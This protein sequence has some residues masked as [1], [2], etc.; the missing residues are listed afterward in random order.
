MRK[1]ALQTTPP[2]R[3]HSPD[4]CMVSQVGEVYGE[5]DLAR[6]RVQV[7]GLAVALRVMVQQGMHELGLQALRINTTP[8]RDRCM[9]SQI[10]RGRARR[11]R[12]WQWRCA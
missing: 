1:P 7:P 8:V 3:T 4:G 9:V 6:V 5:P 10:W 12:V 11:C 2:G